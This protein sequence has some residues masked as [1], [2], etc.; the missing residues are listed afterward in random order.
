MRNPN[1]KVETLK[2]GDIT[3][4]EVAVIYIKGI[5]NEE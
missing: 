4:T 2:I 3:K 5:A 1:L